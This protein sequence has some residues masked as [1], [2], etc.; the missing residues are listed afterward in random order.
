MDNIYKLT[1]EFAKWMAAKNLHLELLNLGEGFATVTMPITKKVLTPYDVGI[2]VG[3]FTFTASIMTGLYAARTLIELSD[4]ALHTKT[5]KFL[6]PTIARRE[7]LSLWFYAN[8]L[9][10]RA[11]VDIK[12]HKQKDIIVEISARTLYKECGHFVALFVIKPKEA[13]DKILGRAEKADG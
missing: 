4:Y 1:E 7:D 13:M 10:E 9:N 2:V 11:W 8:V 6:L 5:L 12:G 3:A